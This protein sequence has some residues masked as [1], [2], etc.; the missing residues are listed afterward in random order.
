MD[1]YGASSGKIL[2][3][4]DSEG[5]EENHNFFFFLIWENQSS[6]YSKARVKINDF[7]NY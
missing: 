6:F 4:I 2:A 5:R 7:K 3:T 1:G